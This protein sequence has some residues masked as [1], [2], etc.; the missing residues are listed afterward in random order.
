ML[1]NKT[2]FVILDSFDV[3]LKETASLDQVVFVYVWHHVCNGGG[4]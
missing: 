3:T 2:A 1:F 4:I